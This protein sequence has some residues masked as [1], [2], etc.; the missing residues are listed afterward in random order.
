MLFER[1]NYSK[2]VVKLNYPYRPHPLRLPCRLKPYPVPDDLRECFTEQGQEEDAEERVL[3]VRPQ[4]GEPLCMENYFERFSALLFVEELRREE[5]MRRFDM[6]SVS[7][8][9]VTVM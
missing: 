1:S 7:S 9:H 4:L 3:S 8:N 5:D 6:C 2:L